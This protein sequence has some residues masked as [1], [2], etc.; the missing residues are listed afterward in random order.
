MT[1]AKWRR[2]LSAV[3]Q[4]NLTVVGVIEPVLERLDQMEIELAAKLDGLATARA[5][6]SANRSGLEVLALSI[7]AMLPV[8]LLAVLVVIG[9]R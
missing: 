3:K 6:S 9:L 8:V 1:S 2:T 4:P 7:A 5:P